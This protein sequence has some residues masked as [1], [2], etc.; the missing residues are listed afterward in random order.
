MVANHEI[1]DVLDANVETPDAL[2]GGGEHFDD[3]PRALA[4]TGQSI[5]MLRRHVVN[6]ACMWRVNIWSV[7]MQIKVLN[8]SMTKTFRTQK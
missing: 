4:M 8:H 1:L 5:M 7:L 3:V 2:I 6:Y